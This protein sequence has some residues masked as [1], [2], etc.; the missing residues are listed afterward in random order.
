M[1]SHFQS[2]A[3]AELRPAI[4][5]SAAAG[6]VAVVLAFAMPETFPPAWLWSLPAAAFLGAT[7]WAWAMSYRRLQILRDIPE[8]KLISAAQGYASLEGRAAAFPGKPLL[9]PLTAQPCCWYSYAIS[10]RH[11]EKGSRAGSWRETSEWSFMMSDGT[12][13]C[14]VDPVGANLSPSRVKKWNDTE[15]DYVERLILPGDLLF[16]AGKL[17]TSSATVTGHDIEFRTGELIAEWKKDMRWIKQRFDL[18]GDGQFSGQEWDLVRHQARREVE[19][20]LARHPPLPQNLISDPG[21]GRPF[22]ISASSRQR[23]EK[24]QNLWVLLH[25]AC[26]LSGAALLAWLVFRPPA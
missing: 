18:D 5:A 23:L 15:R 25:L 24:D 26:L 6:L 12:G 4:A 10:L 14:V 22:V 13:E 2:M 17:T 1:A 8:S 21:D 20:Q 19:A 9:S 11:A 3:A 7:F 16:V